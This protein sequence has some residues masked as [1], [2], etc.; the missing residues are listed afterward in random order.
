M[1]DM[2]D[3]LHELLQ[4]KADQVP[5]HRD[6]PRSL[7][8]RARRRIVVNVLGTGL[9]VAVLASGAFAGLRALGAVPVQQPA[10]VPTTS[11]APRTQT[12]PTISA[13]MSAQLRAVG[14]MG[15]AAGS[16]EGSI[17][18]TNFSD[19]TCTLQGTPSIT[20]LD[21]NLKLITSDVAFSSAPPGWRVNGSPRPAGWPVVSLRPG[22]SASVRIRWSNWC[23]DGR[24][25]PLWRLDIPGGGT[26][27]IVNGMDA[28]SPPPCNGSGQPST[29]EEGPLEPGTNP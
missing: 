20:L 15:G 16:R 19:A 8:G 5:P 21:Q 11:S 4:R 1:N 23:P 17:G 9:M 14:S 22:D 12:A 25:A 27:D 13:C 26:V 3:D 18:L 2:R 28:V 10:G 29:I 24:T 7:A 6:V